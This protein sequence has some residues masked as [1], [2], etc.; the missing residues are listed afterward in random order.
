MLGTKKAR[1][2]FAVTILCAV[3]FVPQAFAIESTSQP[4]ATK[5]QEPKTTTQSDTST[6][7]TQTRCQAIDQIAVRMQTDLTD[8]KAQVDKKRESLTV[9][10]A[11]RTDKRQSQLQEKRLQWDAKRQENFEKI[12]AKAE[13]DE[14]KKAVEVYVTAMTDAIEVRRTAND[15]AFAAFRVDLEAIKSNIDQSVQQNLLATQA[16]VTQAIANAKAAC[17]S[18]QDVAKIKETLKLEMQAAKEKSKTSRQEALKNEQFTAAVEKR[19]QAVKTNSA[20]FL[21]STKAAREE[22]LQVFRD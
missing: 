10:A 11:E 4:P 6:K 20:V 12:R 19:N 14:Q 15:A 2:L 3:M 22:L 8:K 16:A 1:S 21:Q 17:E 7:S 5:K 9:Q 13:T 18:G